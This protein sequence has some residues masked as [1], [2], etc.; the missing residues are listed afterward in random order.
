[1]P[2]DWDQGATCE[3]SWKVV[4]DLDGAR[5][6]FCLLCCIWIHVYKV[7]MVCF[8]L[9]F[10]RVSS[11]KGVGVNDTIMFDTRTSCPDSASCKELH[12]FVEPEFQY[13]EQY[14][15][16]VFINYPMSTWDGKPLE[17]ITFVAKEKYYSAKRRRLFSERTSAG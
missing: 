6:G 3:V 13:R 17:T 14:V 11:N 9:V 12:D 1:M 15:L 4:D 8:Y 10:C 2:Y 7:Y 5:E 16:H